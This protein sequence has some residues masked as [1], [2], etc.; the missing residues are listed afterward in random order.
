MRW[1]AWLS[2]LDIFLFYFSTAEVLSPSSTR[3][4]R[5]CLGSS[6]PLDCEVRVLPDQHHL[7]SLDVHRRADDGTFVLRLGLQLSSALPSLLVSTGPLQFDI[8]HGLLDLPRRHRFHSGRETL[9]RK[10][11][12][13]TAMICSTVLFCT[14]S[15]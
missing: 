7:L 6:L 8:D 11:G 5:P 3:S 13:G 10:R 15:C 14:C 12:T 4:L 2:E 9:G 1:P